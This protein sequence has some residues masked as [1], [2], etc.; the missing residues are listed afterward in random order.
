MSWLLITGTKWVPD[1]LVH[2]LEKQYDILDLTKMYV[3]GNV[4]ILVLGGGS[5]F[6]LGISPQDRLSNNSLARLNEVFVKSIPDSKLLVFSGFSSKNG[7]SRR[8]SQEMLQ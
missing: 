5:T 2:G 7:I 1:L 3:R 6:D 4:F 8:L